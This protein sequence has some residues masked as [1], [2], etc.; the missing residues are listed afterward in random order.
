MSLAREV[1]VFL[2]VGG[3]AVALDAIAYAALLSLG[4]P[5]APAKAT[6]FC[7]GAL[8]AYH[9]NKRLTFRAEHARPLRF[10]AVYL[11][12]LALNVALNAFI[13]FCA[14]SLSIQG[15]LPVAVGFLVATGASATAN[16]IGMRLMVFRR[17]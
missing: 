15:W 7:A 17:D 14:A 9:A 11:A 8:W 5:S 2:P 10:V 4:V 12:S 6:G 13:L 3:A 1:V 16:F